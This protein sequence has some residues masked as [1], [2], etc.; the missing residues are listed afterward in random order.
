MVRGLR[1]FKICGEGE[2]PKTI[3]LK[4]Q[5]AKGKAL[6]SLWPRAGPG[7]E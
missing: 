5:P 1:S 3:L 4:G 7:G 2:F 6:C